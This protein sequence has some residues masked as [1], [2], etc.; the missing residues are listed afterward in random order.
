MNGPGN[1]RRLGEAVLEQRE[2]LWRVI[3][4]GTHIAEVPDEGEGAAAVSFICALAGIGR[5]RLERG[6]RSL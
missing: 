4:D 3:L 1:W 2:E 6:S 5:P